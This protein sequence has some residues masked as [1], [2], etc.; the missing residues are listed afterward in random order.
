MKLPDERA[1]YR[2][3]LEGD[4]AAFDRF[5]NE[6]F[7]RLYRFILTRV[8][9]D[10]EAAQTLCQQALVEG[11]TRF[12]RYRGEA[13]LFTWLCQIARGHIDAWWSL[14][15]ASAQ[16]RL[17]VEDD[18]LV[19]AAVESLLAPPQPQGGTVHRDA[20]IARLVQV[21]LD[22]L[23]VHYGSVLEWKYVDGLSAAEVAQRLD[24]PL[25]V[26]Q[27]LL[28]HARAAF[29]EVFATLLGPELAGPELAHAMP[30]RHGDGP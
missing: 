25:L 28:A 16:R 9:E 30:S 20:Q 10:Q 24:Q 3:L 23:P 5:F 26:T 27:A 29:R 4:Q 12:A 11:V 22:Q 17:H 2:G 15:N 18:A 1:A 8:G 14:Q 19:R 21:A 13:A 7:P 6:F